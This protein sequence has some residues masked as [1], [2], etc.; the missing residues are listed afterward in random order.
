MAGQA[1]Y[2]A[3][4]GNIPM[5]RKLLALVAQ[6][7]RHSNSPHPYGSVK[8]SVAAVFSAMAEC[9]G[10]RKHR[11][12]AILKTLPPDSPAPVRLLSE[13]VDAFCRDNGMRSDDISSMLESITGGYTGV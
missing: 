12:R 8:R 5:S 1:L 3:G 7:Q 13:A 11:A 4:A 10:G 9:F 6:K 2:A